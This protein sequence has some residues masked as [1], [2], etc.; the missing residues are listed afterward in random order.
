MSDSKILFKR[1][2][3]N[4]CELCGEL[5]N[6]KDKKALAKYYCEKCLRK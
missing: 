2:V 4:S 3:E 5:M 6:D 1:E